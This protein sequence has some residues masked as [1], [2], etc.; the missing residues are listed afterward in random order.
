MGTSIGSTEGA[1]VGT[2]NGLVEGLFVVIF[3]GLS[4]GLRDGFALG[5]FIGETDGVLD[6]RLVDEDA[7]FV[8]LLFVF[9]AS[10]SSNIDSNIVYVM[11]P[12]PL[13]GS[14]PLVALKPD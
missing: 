7:L 10:K 9:A 12:R 14:Q 11:L 4:V 3:D 2:F 1:F 6:A 8:L 13:K 5:R